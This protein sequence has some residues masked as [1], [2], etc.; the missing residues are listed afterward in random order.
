M[1]FA[2]L[3][4]GQGADDDVQIAVAQHFGRRIRLSVSSDLADEFV[5]YLETDL[6]VSLLAAFEPEFD[7]N[8][9]IIA[10]EL[11]SVIALHRQVVRI[12]GCGEL[13]LFHSA[14]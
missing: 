14:G 10:K 1:G 8:F 11:D 12:N 13:Q 6:L 5:H 3:A 7:A 2:A 9:E 4:A